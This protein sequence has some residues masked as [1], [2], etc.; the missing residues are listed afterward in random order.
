MVKMKNTEKIILGMVAVVALIYLASNLNLFSFVA[1]GGSYGYN[2]SCVIS[3]STLNCNYIAH[4]T[5]AVYT[6]E[7]ITASNTCQP[8][9]KTFMFGNADVL[10][11]GTPI[12]SDCPHNTC[13]GVNVASAMITFPAGAVML[14]EQDM[15]IMKVG[16]WD[17]KLT[18][19]PD[20]WGGQHC[21]CLITPQDVQKMNVQVSNIPAGNHIITVRFDAQEQFNSQAQSQ[22]YQMDYRNGQSFTFTYQVSGAA[23]PTPTPVVTPTPSLYPSPTPPPSINWLD[24]IWG[25]IHNILCSIGILTGC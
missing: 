4:T 24:S 11:D 2:D 8:E 9:G 10:L 23:P 6:N 25:F 3:G 7:P 12:V 15:R 21:D 18:C 5:K 17:Y 1:G 19:V 13:A 20:R 14:Q 22:A 16:N